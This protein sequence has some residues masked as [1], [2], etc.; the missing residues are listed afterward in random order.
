L[1]KAEELEGKAK[2]AE[3]AGDK[4]KA[5]EYYLRSSAVYRISR[6]PAPRSEKQWKAWEKGKEV[7]LKGFKLK[8]EVEGYSPIHQVDIPHK[9]KAGNDK[10]VLP[11]FVQ[12]PDRATS[13]KPS[14]A[15]IIMTG[16]DGYRTELAVWAEGWRQIGVAT[17]IMEIP[18]TGDSP[19]DPKDPKSPDRQWSTL[20]DWIDE[21]AKIDSKKLATWGFSTGGFYTTRAAYTHHDRLLGAVNL[22]GGMHHLFDREW[23][24]EVNHLEYP[25]E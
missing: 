24:D 11:V 7:V 17:I 6:F 20:L 14:P 3:A 23:L 25:F 16:L 13:E 4:D 10:D 12:I 22:G 1:P 18:G 21:Q 8:G 19:A 9:H 5:A 2:E 15:V